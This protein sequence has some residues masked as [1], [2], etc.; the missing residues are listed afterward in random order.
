M[1]LFERQVEI[2]RR[3]AAREDCDIVGYGGAY[4]LPRHA[5]T[6]NFYFHA[7]LEFRV[8]RVME[9]YKIADRERAV[10]LIANSDETR[11]RYFKQI[12]GRYRAYPDNYHVC[13]DTS[14]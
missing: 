11:Q 12:T 5:R 13:M 3:I 10:Q 6:V 8:R 7:P 9:P 14:M 1:D 2:L 4:V